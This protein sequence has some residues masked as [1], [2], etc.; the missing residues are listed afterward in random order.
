MLA[1]LLKHGRVSRHFEPVGKFYK[2]ICYLNSTRKSV[3][4]SCCERFTE[5]KDLVTVMFRYNGG[6]E[7]YKI[8]VGMPLLAT[9]NLKDEEI[10]NTMEFKLEDIRRK[11]EHE[12]KVKGT[13]FS[14]N[15]FACSF[16]PAFCVT[17]YKFQGCDIDEH[18]NVFDTRLM[19]KKQIYTAL[20][21]TTKIEYI[22]LNNNELNSRYFIREQPVEEIAKSNHDNIYNN[23]KIYKVTFSNGKVYVGSTCLSLDERLKSH[24]SDTKSQVYKYSKY[25]PKI[26]LIVKAPTFDKKKLEEIECKWIERYAEDCGEQLLNIRGNPSKKG[27]RKTIEHEVVIESDKQL[28]ARVEQLEGKIVIRDNPE[29]GYWLFDT[30]IN[31]KRY[32]NISKYKSGSKEDAFERLSAKKRKLIE[33][34]TVEW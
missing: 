27:P 31:G 23:G 19:D 34:L 11:H 10:F 8:C 7:S 25:K 30:V 13:W 6:R 1:N 3:N 20:S 17:V 4:E 12:F 26:E 28:V 21:R 22:H 5:E 33:D 18:Y 15:V 16:I 24:L 29:I 14:L 9:Q 2:N 32:R